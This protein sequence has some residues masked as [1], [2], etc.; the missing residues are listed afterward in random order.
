LKSFVRDTAKF[1]RTKPHRSEP[2]S[3]DPRT[4]I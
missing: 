3:N 2:I 1:I 4:R